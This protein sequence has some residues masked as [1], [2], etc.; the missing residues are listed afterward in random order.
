MIK[1]LKADATDE[2]RQIA[3]VLWQRSDSELSMNAKF[4]EEF[5]LTPVHA[6]VLHLFDNQDEQPDL[7]EL[8]ELISQMKNNKHDRNWDQ[9]KKKYHQ[10]SPLFTEIIEQ[11]ETY[12]RQQSQGSR[13]GELDTPE[14]IDQGDI[15]GWTPLHW[16]AYVGRF[17]ELKILLEF[18]A[19]PLLITS[20]RRNVFHHAAES[21]HAQM[22]EHLSRQPFI[23]ANVKVNLQDLWGETPLHIAVARSAGSV[24]ALLDLNATVTLKQAD[25]RN[26]LHDAYLATEENDNRYDIVRRLCDRDSS[27]VHVVDAAGKTPVF[28]LLNDSRCVALLIEHKAKLDLHDKQKR[29]LL[30][31]ACKTGNPEVLKTLLSRLKPRTFKLVKMVTAL[32]T[33]GSTPLRE[34]FLS[35]SAL[36]VLQLL[37]LSVAPLNAFIGPDGWNVLHHAARLGSC[38]VVETVL[39]S[40]RWE[41]S[42]LLRRTNDGKTAEQIAR[43]AGHYEGR[44][45]ELLD[46]VKIEQQRVESLAYFASLR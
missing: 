17:E 25:D 35:D 37:S 36:C 3:D 40:R 44:F 45:Q 4:R 32:D 12:Y 18:S 46:S 5:R 29:N 43:D 34:A 11:F 13:K 8:L 16:A 23:Q 22:M 30:H 14:P 39:N 6:C 2:E 42:E 9:L 24:K 20:S 31:Y 33:L 28:E 27:I 21:G 10:R 38:E 7:T 19:N 1:S 41:R 15:N 26:P